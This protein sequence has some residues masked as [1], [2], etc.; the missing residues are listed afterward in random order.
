MQSDHWE[1][2]E[3]TVTLLSNEYEKR[4]KALRKYTRQGFAEPAGDPRTDKTKDIWEQAQYKGAEAISIFYQLI[5]E[6]PAEPADLK[7]KRLFY[8]EHQMSS[9]CLGMSCAALFPILFGV[10]QGCIVA[11]S[12]E[13]TILVANYCCKSCVGESRGPPGFEDIILCHYLNLAVRC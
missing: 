7:V 2:M 3:E 4:S 6:A 5:A 10:I 11:T 9:E 13:W 12:Y 8:D 1:G